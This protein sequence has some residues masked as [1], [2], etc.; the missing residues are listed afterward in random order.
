MIRN[1]IG[2]T[3]PLTLIRRNAYV[4]HG[5]GVRGIRY[6]LTALAPRLHLHLAMIDRFEGKEGEG[7]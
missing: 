1:Y 4:I 6:N 3:K 7:S 5:G 2:L